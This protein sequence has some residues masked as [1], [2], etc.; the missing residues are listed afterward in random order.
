ML[1]GYEDQIRIGETGVVG[2]PAHRIDVDDPFA[3]S[4]HEGAVAN[5][6]DGEFAG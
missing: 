2:F 6:V 5:E 3:E 1:V 4:E